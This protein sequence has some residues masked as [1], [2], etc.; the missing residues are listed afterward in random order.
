L[1]EKRIIIS[2][3]NQARGFAFAKQNGGS[4]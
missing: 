4:A 1:Q 2:G 3:V